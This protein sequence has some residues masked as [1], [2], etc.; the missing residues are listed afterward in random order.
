VTLLS[1]YRSAAQT[2]F[3]CFLSVRKRER[4]RC[5]VDFLTYNAALGSFVRRDSY[6]ASGA[7]WLQCYMLCAWCHHRMYMCVCASLT[8]A[9]SSS[10]IIYISRDVC[11]LGGPFKEVH[12]HF[13]RSSVTYLPGFAVICLRIIFMNASVLHY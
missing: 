7:V 8:S 4:E 2:L 5:A 11:H 3:L 10:V 6:F 9:L 13:T 1:L 12:L